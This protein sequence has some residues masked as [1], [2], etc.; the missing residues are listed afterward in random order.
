MLED[1]MCTELVLIKVSGFLQTYFSPWKSYF[2]YIKRSSAL[3]HDQLEL[4]GDEDDAIL[5]KH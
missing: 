3:I 5:T 1:E 4:I 2:V